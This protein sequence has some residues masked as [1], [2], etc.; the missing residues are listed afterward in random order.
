MP[1]SLSNWFQGF[2]KRTKL[3]EPRPRKR[4]KPTAGPL[5]LEEEESLDC[6]RCGVRLIACGASK[7]SRYAR[8]ARLCAHCYNTRGARA[9][10][11]AEKA[12]THGTCARCGRDAVASGDSRHAAR[13]RRMRV[14]WKCYRLDRVGKH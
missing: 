6:R 7:A 11:M 2:A 8:R 1:E 14:C 3:I 9:Y 13:A 12:K 4:S 10:A 5:I